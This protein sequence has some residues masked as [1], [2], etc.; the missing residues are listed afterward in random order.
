YS[1]ARLAA[2]SYGDRVSVIDTGTAAGAEGLVALAAAELARAGADLPAVVAR[3]T[4]V[5]DRVR[6]VATVDSIDHLLRSRPVPAGAGW[7]GKRLGVNPLFQFLKGEVHPMR[8]ALSRAA[9]I[10]RI[11]HAVEGSAPMGPATLRCAALHALSPD[12]AE[13]LVTELER[14]ADDSQV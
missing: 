7:A 10:D 3:A 4:D 2:S 11:V 1:S 6:L 12:V 13:Q 9:A 14:V 8:P 5:M